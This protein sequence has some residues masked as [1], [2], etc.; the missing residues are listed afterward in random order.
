MGGPQ[1]TKAPRFF[2]SIVSARLLNVTSLNKS[3]FI[4]FESDISLTPGQRKWPHFIDFEIEDSYE[5]P[6]ITYGKML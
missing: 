4:F 6:K 3:G 1:G 2:L 5:G